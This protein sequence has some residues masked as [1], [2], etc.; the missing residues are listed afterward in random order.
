MIDI[1][2]YKTQTESNH[3]D[4]TLYAPITM[5]GTL[6]EP[7]NVIDPVITIT[8]SNPESY[9]YMHISPICTYFHILN[10]FCG[11]LVISRSPFF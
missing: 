1:I 3:M 9:N 11:L 4:K 8:T 5:E 10:G 2:L 6:K 7:T